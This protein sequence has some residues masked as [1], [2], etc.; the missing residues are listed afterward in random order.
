MTF[1]ALKQIN[2]HVVLELRQHTSVFHRHHCTTFIAITAQPTAITA[3]PQPQPSSAIPDRTHW[4]PTG[5][6]WAR[7]LPA[8]VGIPGGDPVKLLPHDSSS[9]S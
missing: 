2:L 6:V 7:G 9:P 4:E 1:I 3:Q 8:G 5:T